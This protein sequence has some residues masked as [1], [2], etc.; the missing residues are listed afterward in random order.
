MKTS[1][2]TASGDSDFERAVELL[3]SRGKRIYVVS[4]K[5]VL[6]REL[7]YVADKPIFLLED[8]RPALE[9]DDRKRASE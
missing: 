5:A 9:R 3:R 4:A 8:F 6:S 7:S 1:P 2:A